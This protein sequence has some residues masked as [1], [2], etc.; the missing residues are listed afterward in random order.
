MNNLAK[1]GIEFAEAV[2]KDGQILIIEKLRFYK[3]SHI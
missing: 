3:Y 1:F 2:H